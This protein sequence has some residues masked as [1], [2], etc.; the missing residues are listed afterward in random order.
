[1]LVL[2][3]SYA[4]GGGKAQRVPPL[5]CLAEMSSEVSFTEMAKLIKPELFAVGV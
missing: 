4:D 1:M 5:C 3:L 2:I